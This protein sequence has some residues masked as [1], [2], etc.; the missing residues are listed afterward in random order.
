M[1]MTTSYINYVNL[2]SNSLLEKQDLY[3]KVKL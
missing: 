1:I 2:I 3:I